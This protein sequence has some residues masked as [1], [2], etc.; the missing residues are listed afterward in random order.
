MDRLLTQEEALEASLQ[1]KENGLDI[2]TIYL[3]AQ[4]AKTASLVAQEIFTELEEYFGLHETDCN[5]AEVLV[6]LVVNDDVVMNYGNKAMN[7]LNIYQAIKSKWG[8][9]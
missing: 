1:D 8:I 6:K 2:I 9:E 3:K 5:G 7:Q 4:D